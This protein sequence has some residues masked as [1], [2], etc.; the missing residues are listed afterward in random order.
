MLQ[1][2]VNKK[3]LAD[4]REYIKHN[5]LLF[6]KGSYK[7]YIKATCLSTGPNTNKGY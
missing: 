3:L 5:P 4:G 2:P 6:S 7:L 1:G